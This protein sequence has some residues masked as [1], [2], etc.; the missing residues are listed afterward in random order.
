MEYWKEV[1]KLMKA[2]RI[3]LPC[4]TISLFNYDMGLQEKFLFLNNGIFF[5]LNDVMC[6]TIH[7]PS[8]KRC[9]C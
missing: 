5:R 7:R 4:G 1:R 9:V 3:S 8:S 2:L 6:G